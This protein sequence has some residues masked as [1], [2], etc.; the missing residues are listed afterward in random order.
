MPGRADAALRAAA[1]DERALHGVQHVAAR[2]PLDRRDRAAVALARR[3]EARVD[4]LAVEHHRARAA[5][6][7]AAALLRAGEPQVLAQHVE[8]ALPRRALD[9]ARLRR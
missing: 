9:G 8:Q 2:E 6:A 3:D 1:R 5:L 4:D 7:F